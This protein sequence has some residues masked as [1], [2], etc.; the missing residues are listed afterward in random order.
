VSNL[1]SVF[2]LPS[3]PTVGIEEEVMLLDPDT[4]DLAP[5]ADEAL[6]LIGGDPRFKRELPAAQLEI[7]T[8][9]C[10]SVADAAD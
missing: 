7:I 9:P 1:R 6:A 2:A 5:H 4:L 10:A 8:K 3:P